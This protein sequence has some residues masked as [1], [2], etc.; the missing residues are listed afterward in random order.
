MR[1]GEATLS[2]KHGHI[3]GRELNTEGRSWKL[4]GTMDATGFLAG[5]Y[6]A[7]D[8]HDTGNGTFFLR[9]EGSDMYGFWAGYDSVNRQVVSG[10][11]TFRQR[12][13]GKVRRATPDEAGRVVALL[14]DTLGEFYV[15]IGTVEEAIAGDG[16]AT[17]LVEVDS[18]NR[19]LGAVTCYIVSPDS[20]ARFLP[21]GQE[22]LIN[23]LR[24]LKFNTSI[25]LLRSIAVAPNYRRRGVATDLTKHC[26]GW[27]AKHGA[28]AML[29]F[30]WLP[31]TDPQQAV[32][33][34]AGVLTH[35]GFTPVDRIDHY[36]TRDSRSKC[37]QC[38]VCG[39]T[40]MCAAV[41]YTRAILEPASGGSAA[42]A[43]IAP[44][45]PKPRGGPSNQD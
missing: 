24:V 19:L 39:P 15:D 4:E 44:T 8:P 29:T 22:D 11:Y 6:R 1:D 35:T 17:C 3:S 18:S 31:H 40:C 33:Q 34:L 38:A 20:L 45:A 26:I 14:G 28:S 43:H 36:W 41:V 7:D 32:P 12:P 25:G 5:I 10:T 16:T 27:C 21:E 9:I 2:W 13:R 37:Y 42:L 23:R 30:A